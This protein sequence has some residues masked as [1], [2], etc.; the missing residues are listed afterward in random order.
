MPV[1]LSV[2]LSRVVLLALAGTLGG[3]AGQ[4]VLALCLG[5]GWEVLRHVDAT[6]VAW[7]IALGGIPGLILGLASR[8]H[9]DSNLVSRKLLW[10]LLGSFVMAAV[11]CLVVPLILLLRFG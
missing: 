7:G 3:I 5:S 2:H 4:G 10:A 8:R 9:F 6:V 11:I 1:S